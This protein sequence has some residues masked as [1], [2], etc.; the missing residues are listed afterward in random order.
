MSA[1]AILA[2]IGGIVLSRHDTWLET[3]LEPTFADSTIHPA[4]RLAARARAS[5]SARCSR[6]AGI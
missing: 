5:S 3:F 6:L 2:I 1:L 4:E